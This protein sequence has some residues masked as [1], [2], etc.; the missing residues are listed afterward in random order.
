MNEAAN[1]AMEAPSHKKL[2]NCCLRRGFLNGV[3][4][5]PQCGQ[6]RFDTPA[7]NPLA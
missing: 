1:E 3:N 5:F 6:R 4:A 2:N 7:I